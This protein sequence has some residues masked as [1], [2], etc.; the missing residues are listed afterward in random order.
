M[1]GKRKG[2]GTGLDALLSGEARR[3]PVSKPRDASGT[4][5]KSAGSENDAA[6]G[7]KELPVDLLVRGEMQPRVDMR[8]EALQ[9]LAD[10]IK[11]QGI[12]QPIL[13]R[14][15]KGGKYEIVAGERRWRAAQLAGLSKVPAVVRELDDTQATALALIEN[16]QRE[17]L[18]PM[19]ESRGLFK[20]KQKTECTHQEL[21]QMVGRSRA[22]VSNLMRLMEL[23]VDVQKMLESRELEM[24]HARA[25]LGLSGRQ[26][27][28]AGRDVVAGGLSVRATER[29][30]QSLTK[31]KPVKKAT[32]TIDNDV[33][34]LENQLSETLGAKVAFQQGVG[35]K[36]KLLISYNSLEELEG[37]L[38]HIK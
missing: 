16:M 12:A 25:L 6:T 11:S 35:G 33:R 22:S 4:T 7:L 9:E 26:Q 32:R 2:L 19:E 24:G 8:P 38:A 23:E 28:R 30:V 18:N 37:I 14:P 5:A 31:S 36:G 17:D 10:S 1:A 29:L 34:R 15:A 3:N 20:L 21:A 13:V 27:I